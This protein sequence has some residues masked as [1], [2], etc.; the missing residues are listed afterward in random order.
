M[1]FV[2]FLNNVIPARSDCEMVI[3]RVAVLL[4]PVTGN[5]VSLEALQKDHGLV[6]TIDMI[7]SEAL[8]K[9]PE[10][11]RAYITAMLRRGEKFN[12]LPRIATSTIHGSKGGEADN[13]VLITDLSPAADDDMRINPDD[14]HRVFY[15]GVTRTR[16]KLYIVEPE[17]VTRSYYI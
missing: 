8:D 2:S 4:R 7:W 14:I 6:A 5:Q 1:R 9:I 3:L 17:D 10:S 12:G 15:V 16:D 11:E 13:V